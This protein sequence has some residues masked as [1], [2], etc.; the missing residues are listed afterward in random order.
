M[1]EEYIM[2]LLDKTDADLEWFSKNLHWLKEKY[3]DELIAF[4]EGKVI[5]HDK[6]METLLN[7]VMAQG[8]RPNDI[9]IQFVSKRKRVF[10]ENSPSLCWFEG[11]RNR[12]KNCGNN[13]RAW[14]TTRF[15]CRS[16]AQA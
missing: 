16:Q 11:M 2:Q 4:E 9:M 13:K 15:T 14:Q 12:F 1:K 8:K 3:N 5:A 10:Y 6:D 7:K